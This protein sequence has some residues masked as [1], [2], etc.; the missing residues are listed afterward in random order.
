MTRGKYHLITICY[1]IINYV[2]SGESRVKIAAAIVVASG[3][4]LPVVHAGEISG[5]PPHLVPTISPDYTFYFG[6]DFL[7]SGTT[8]DFRTQQLI[9]IANIKDRWV[10]VLDHSML[11]RAD[12]VSGPPARI[13][14]MSLS[15]GYK[16]IND[17]SFE[18]S[19]S[20]TLGIGAR[21]VGNYEGARI[22]NGFHTLIESDTSFLPYATTRQTDATLWFMAERHQLLR[23]AK[24]KGLISGWDTGYWARAGALTTADGQ[25]DGVAGLYAVASRPGFDLWLGLRQDWREGYS[26]D[27][28]QIE[29]AAEESKTAISY[30]IRLG[31]L[32]IETVQ[33]FDSSASYGQL[34]FV[35][36]AAT[37]KNPTGRRSRADVQLGLYLPH[38]MFQLA[39]RWHTRL[40]TGADSLWRESILVDL[41]GGQP[42]L[43]RDVTRF[44][45]TAQL[46]AGL[47]FSRPISDSVSWLRFYSA[48]SLGWRSEQLV[49]HGELDGVRSESIGK[50]VLQADVGLEIDAARIRSN[51]RHS[52]R[53]GLSGW[54]PAESVTVMDGGL[55]SELHKPGASIAVIWTFNYH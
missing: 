47:E 43:G 13:D 1:K 9:A 55:A 11:T 50:A 42:Q 15:L 4:L 46:T 14:L 20:L 10:A 21:G 24:G 54:L 25:V 19:K 23:S 36:S 32:V 33:R 3:L 7:A 37:R 30:G 52:L 49:G 53:F 27:I 31:S 22:Q 39:G 2:C 44:T 5:L 29:T 34:S 35:S 40:L 38:M 45:E 6:N 16:V 28:V 8:D 18:R 41:R 26:A 17:Q 12:A 51:W 48:G